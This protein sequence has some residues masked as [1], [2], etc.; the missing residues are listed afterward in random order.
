[1]TKYYFATMTA[2]MLK[3]TDSFGQYN[4]YALN[5]QGFLDAF[6]D[7]N[8]LIVTLVAEGEWSAKVVDVI[9]ASETGAFRD[10]TA[11]PKN[12]LNII[13]KGRDRARSGHANPRGRRTSGCMIGNYWKNLEAVKSLAAN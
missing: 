11:I 9:T 3:K 12:I 8:G 2:D 13:E 10:G 1:M 4:E 6:D 5:V 7:S